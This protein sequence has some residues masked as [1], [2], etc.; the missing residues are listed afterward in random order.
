MSRNTRNYFENTKWAKTMKKS[1]K[2][3]WAG[4]AKMI[5]WAVSMNRTDIM[6][7]VCHDLQGY[8]SKDKFFSPR[9]TRF[10]K[11]SD[12]TKG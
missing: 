7:N 9:S 2:L 8:Q 12:E 1:D 10:Q 6:F 5:L 4:L 3:F 11:L